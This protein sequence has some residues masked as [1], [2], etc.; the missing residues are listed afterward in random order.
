MS[1][2]AQRRTRQPIVSPSRNPNI[3]DR[4]PYLAL[5]GGSQL[6]TAVIPFLPRLAREILQG[7]VQGSVVVVVEGHRRTFIPGFA[8][9]LK[10]GRK[11][12]GGR[13]SR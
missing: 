7:E 4:S 5:A 13:A 8:F 6:N 11:M 2:R 9:H 10:S 3:A 12:T 1:W